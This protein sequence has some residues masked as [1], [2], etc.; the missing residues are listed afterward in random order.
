MT[1]S[2]SGTPLNV[3]GTFDIRITASDGSTSATDTFRLT[4]TPTNSVPVLGG[5]DAPGAFAENTVN[6]TAQLLDTDV[7][8]TDLDEELDGGALT[9]SGLLAE[10]TI[11]IRNQGTAGGE[12]GVSG[13]NVTYGGTT[14][15]TFT[16]GNAGATLTVT[17]SADAT[18]AA[19]EALIENLT[20]ANSS[21]APSASRT[22]EI[23]ITD[24]AGAAAIATVEFARRGGAANP[25]TGLNA[26]NYSTPSFADLDGDGDIDAVVGEGNGTL[27]YFRNTGT[28]TAPVFVQQTGAANP[29]SGVDVGT[30]SAPS[31]ADLDGDGDL[32]AVVGRRQ[33]PPLFPEHRQ[34]RPPS[35]RDRRRQS[36]QQLRCGV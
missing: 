10:D 23:K 17:F 25:F 5:L 21:D 1:R 24:D 34:R 32:D 16:G 36:V 4:V 18:A 22:L 33:R 14:I 7:T 9:V 2:F 12:I 31:L 29:F 28:A 6:D 19:V 3:H 8:F 11:A 20:Y 30:F 35:R 27:Q 15:G 26:G 13:S